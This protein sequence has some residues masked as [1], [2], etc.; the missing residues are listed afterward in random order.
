MA[1]VADVK[2]ERQA[3]LSQKSYKRQGKKPFK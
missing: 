3:D 1:A 2:P